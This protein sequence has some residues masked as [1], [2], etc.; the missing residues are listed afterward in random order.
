[1]KKPLSRIIP[2]VLYLLVIGSI[3]VFIVL[4][5]KSSSRRRWNQPNLLLFIVP[6]RLLMHVWI[7]PFLHRHGII[8]PNFGLH[9]IGLSISRDNLFQLIE[10]IIP[11]SNHVV[12]P[13]IL[14]TYAPGITAAI[15]SLDPVINIGGGGSMKTRFGSARF[16]LARK[17]TL[18][19]QQSAGGSRVDIRFAVLATN[20]M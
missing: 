17:P 19:A 18:R 20:L 3:C 12:P 15:A 4:V 9:P 5:M 6:T 2:G 11:V 1:M 13:A 10:E 7:N 16:F 8:F 14:G